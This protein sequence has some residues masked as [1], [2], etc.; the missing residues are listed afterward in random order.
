MYKKLIISCFVVL[1]IIMSVSYS[2]ADIG[3]DI[4]ERSTAE[5]E[6]TQLQSALRNSDILKSRLNIITQDNEVE[7]DNTV[8][9]EN[10]ITDN[11][12]NDISSANNGIKLYEVFFN[13]ETDSIKE[14]LDKENEMWMFPKTIDDK[15]SFIFMK[16]GEEL[17]AAKKKIDLLKVSEERKE[18]MIQRVAERE[19]KWYVFRIE[20]QNSTDKASQFVNANSINTALNTNSIDNV[21]SVKYIYIINKDILGIWVETAD[22]EYI[23]PYV[24]GNQIESISSNMVYSLSNIVTDIAQ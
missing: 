2:Y 4:I 1:S 13:E 17:S 22:S 24:S 3:Y 21:E 7:S 6:T 14:Q 5:T 9:L 15:I 10:S 23:I 8:I 19:N 18:K 11:V 20:Q 16:K 12:K